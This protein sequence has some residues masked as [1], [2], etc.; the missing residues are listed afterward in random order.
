MMRGDRMSL[1]CSGLLC[2]NGYTM[3]SMLKEKIKDY[4]SGLQELRSPFSFPVGAI[5]AEK[6]DRAALISLLQK[7]SVEVF[8]VSAHHP[9]FLL[10]KLEEAMRGH[11][12][13]AWNLDEPLSGLLMN[14]LSNLAGGFSYVHHV[15]TERPT[16]SATLDGKAKL[17]LLM[18]PDYYENFMGQDIISS[19]CG[20][21]K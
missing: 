8:S 19:V 5:I 4:I 18:E 12:I 17:L 20:V 11:A 13:I 9:D 3:Q 14:Q 7:N 2:Y 16:V 1:A 15:G 6:E 21:F 10:R